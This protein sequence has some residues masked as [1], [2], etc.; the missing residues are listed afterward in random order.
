MKN[1]GKRPSKL[2]IWL[3]AL[4][5]VSFGLRAVGL[6]N[7]YFGLSQDEALF[8]NHLSDKAVTICENEGDCFLPL[9]A[10]FFRLPHFLGTAGPQSIIYWGRLS[11]LIF[12]CLTLLIA[13]RLVRAEKEERKGLGEIFLLILAFTPQLVF[14]GRFFSPSGLG[15]PLFL[16]AFYLVWRRR[17]GG[18]L[19]I[20][21]IFSL[22]AGA[23]FS[24]LYL[25]LPSL[26]LL[27]LA[28]FLIF[29]EKKKLPLRS[30]SFLLVFLTLL[31]TFFLLRSNN[32]L[33]LK[34]TSGFFNDIGFI[35]AI[36]ASRGIEQNF[37]YP[38]LGRILFNKLYFFIF[39][40]A[41]FWGQYSL[42]RIF[43][44]VESGGFS[45]LI[46]NGP[47]LLVFAPFFVWGL[48]KSFNFLPPK[49]A[50]VWLGL[51]FLGGIS[52]S[53]L[54][55]AFNQDAFVLALFPIAFYVALGIVQL[56]KKPFWWKVF[57]FFLGINLL[58]SYFKIFDDFRRSELL[59]N[60]K[61]Y[62]SLMMSK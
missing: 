32:F 14:L 60:Q 42:A 38:L 12:S 49:K 15:L 59:P 1:R 9:S 44:L 36:N 57:L 6:F 54:A 56:G 45:T 21:L 35:N 29:Q 25:F 8:L 43:S 19:S 51:L 7:P 46:A 3:G 31:A 10:W 58:I 16:A 61:L 30:F 55:S 48:L 23:L 39:W 47:M 50:F 62:F 18:W 13:Y 2:K 37:G 20:L 24:S 52:S 40:L 41:N 22:I 17:N 34:R 27:L 28:I 26:F 5:G 11:T 53:L 4:L 33:V